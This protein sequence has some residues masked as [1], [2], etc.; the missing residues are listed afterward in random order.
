M[1]EAA[2]SGM[3]MRK[4]PLRVLCVDDSAV[5]RGFLRRLF[6]QHAATPLDDLPEMELCGLVEDGVECLGAVPR[7]RPDVVVLDLEMPRMHGL[8]V[9]EQLRLEEPGLP[10]IMCS[11]YT[12]EGA[13]STL[14]ALALGAADYVMKPSQQ[15]DLDGA[16]KALSGQ[17]LPKIAALGRRNTPGIA[18]N[19]R[20]AKGERPA[21]LGGQ[22]GIAP[23]K[24]IVIA[25]ST[26]GPSALEQMLPDLAGDFP[27]PIMIVQ[28]MPKLFTG[29]L[30]ERLDRCCH[31]RVVE[32]REGAEVRPGTIWLAPGDAHMEVA[33]GRMGAGGGSPVNL[34]HLHQQR[35]LNHCKPSADYLFSSAALEYGAG[36][37]ALVMTGMGADGVMGARRVHEAGGTVLAQD[38]ASS[39]VWGMPGRV[40][41]AG[42]ARTPL[43][44]AGL[45]AELT[46]RA[47]AGRGGRS[48]PMAN[49]DRKVANDDRKDAA[50][51]RYEGRHG[52]L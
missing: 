21:A 45:A 38:K 41:D 42:L 25:V 24:I 22:P 5:M 16:I 4:T 50:L 8:D 10:V 19:A 32:A 9:L 34:V 20:L 46:M 6:A 17:L 3:E 39:A 31:L 29:A 11:S 7:L 37:L 26:G 13:R 33:R 14:D 28:H 51:P 40:F 52:L 12:E 2:R 44:L 15:S 47:N 30:A 1:S 23:V 35:S 43:P 18:A 49:N 48:A 27:V 36:A